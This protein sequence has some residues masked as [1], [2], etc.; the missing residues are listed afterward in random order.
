MTAGPRPVIFPPM[1][2][3]SRTT[4]EHRPPS[5]RWSKV[6]YAFMGAGLAAIAIGF[7]L[8]AGGSTV[9]APLLLG[10]GYVVLVPLGII[11]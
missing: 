4:G 2:Q 1:P 5:L 8:L 7:F 10:L 3:T 11:R 9:A 6:N